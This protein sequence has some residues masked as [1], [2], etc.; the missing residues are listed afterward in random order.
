MK[1][2]GEKE[3]LKKRSVE[4]DMWNTFHDYFP[5]YIIKFFH[6]NINNNQF[7]MM[8]QCWL[9]KIGLEPVNSTR[10]KEKYST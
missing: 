2:K 1:I 10:L 5:H 7:N 9:G 6:N 4:K 3:A 8:I